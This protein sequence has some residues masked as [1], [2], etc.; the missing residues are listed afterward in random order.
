[1]LGMIMPKSRIRKCMAF[2]KRLQKENNMGTD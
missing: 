2:C 1:M